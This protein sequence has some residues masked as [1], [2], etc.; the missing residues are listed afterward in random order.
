MAKVKKAVFPVAGFGTR[1]LPA[2]KVIPKELLPIVDHPLIHYAVEEAKQAGIE[3]FIFVNGRSKQALEDYFDHAFELE[4][5][6]ETKGKILELNRLQESLLT[7]GQAK[8]IR[9]GKALGLGHAIW[10]ARH[11]IG[12]EPFAVILPDD[13]IISQKSC[14]AQMI[15]IYEKTNASVLSLMKVD[16]KDTDKYGIASL[17]NTSLKVGEYT[18]IKALV[19]K[20]KV[21]NA[22]SEYA[23]IGR[24]ILDPTLF[25]SLSKKEKG[26][27]GE[28]QLTDSLADL[29]NRGEK[30]YGYAF[31]GQRFDCGHALGYVEAQ[32]ATALNRSEI[33]ETL[34]KSLKKLIDEIYF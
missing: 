28:I 13:Y 33:K 29:I 9:Q 32:V 15:E 11:L 20:P 34:K 1:M 25:D 4:Y 5:V 3:E 18:S 30:V 21:E 2:T 6:L 16:K 27:G 23:V 31:E 14:L 22:P 26:Q 8:F 12:Q 17:E 7:E 24:Y 10:C 19:E